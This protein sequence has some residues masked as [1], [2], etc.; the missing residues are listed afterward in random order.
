M[1]AEIMTKAN[2]KEKEIV[3]TLHSKTW[4]G[5]IKWPPFDPQKYLTY[6]RKNLHGVQNIKKCVNYDVNRSR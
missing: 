4:G 1:P 6:I 5:C 2:N 3:V